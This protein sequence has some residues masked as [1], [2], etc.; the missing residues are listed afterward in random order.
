MSLIHTTPL[1]T[2]VI[3]VGSS[4]LIDATTGGVRQQWLQSL[5]ADLAQ[6]HHLGRHIMVVTSGAVAL[7]RAALKL[8]KRKLLLEEKQAA[9]SIGQIAL[10]R[11]WSAAL[12]EHGLAVGQILLTLG[13]T[14]ERRRYLNA[15]A[16]IGELW[17][18]KAV[19][20]VNE[21]D[22]VATTEIRYGDNDRLAARVA[23]MMGADVLVLFSDV[24]GLYTAN[25][26]S[27]PNAQHLPLIDHITS[28]I[29]AMAGGEGSEF[30]RGGMRTK[31]EAAKMATAAGTHMIIADGRGH[32]PLGRLFNTENQAK[33]TWFRATGTP[34]A[35]RKRW[36]AAVLE[37]K[38]ALII[39]A[40]AVKALKAG[41]SLLPAGVRHMEGMFDRGDLVIVKS[42]EGTE[43]ARGLIAYE[44]ADAQRMIGKQSG[45]IIALLG[46]EGRSEIIH[47]DDMVM[48]AEKEA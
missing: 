6:Q 42:E 39:D 10:A 45:D 5:A 35:H 31:M 27:D 15:R 24:D 33:H 30:S 7:G 14:E 32:N 48:A 38:G 26:R 8:P 23:T 4:L 22:T 19:P 37:P 12:G 28:D 34:I 20:L 18:R 43:I 36:I 3:K 25:P 47:R 11:E 21:N 46:Y 40:G 13:D 29:E 16:T 9:A 2:L 1:S 17:K 41:K 44:T